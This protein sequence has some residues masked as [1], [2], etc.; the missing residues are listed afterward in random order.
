[1]RLKF[2]LVVNR[3]KIFD[4]ENIALQRSESAVVNPPSLNTGTIVEANAMVSKK[5]FCHFLSPD[6]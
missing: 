2:S 5:V 1:M 3:Q 4:H 6:S